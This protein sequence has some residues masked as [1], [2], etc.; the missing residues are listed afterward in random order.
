[1]AE[2]TATEV[3]ATQS[4]PVGGGNDGVTPTAALGGL[5]GDG[6]RLG[7]GLLGSAAAI[8]ESSAGPLLLLFGGGVAIAL[9]LGGRR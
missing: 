1:M 9:V 7:R 5:A 6:V 4:T 3:S 8:A 2:D